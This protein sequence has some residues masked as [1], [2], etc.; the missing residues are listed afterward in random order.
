M[1]RF[2]QGKHAYAI[3]DR[4][5]FRYKY[6]DMRKEWNGSLVGK[7]EFEAKQPQ[8]EPFPTVVDALALKDARPDRIEP[9]TVTVG[10]GGFPNRG[11]AIR[12]IASVGEVTVTT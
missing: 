1:A 12:A 5:G 6:K 4:S 7:D 11:V 10:P 2:A 9:Q 3:S 8:L